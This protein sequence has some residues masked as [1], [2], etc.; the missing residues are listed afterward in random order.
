MARPNERQLSAAMNSHED[1]YDYYGLRIV[2]RKLTRNAVLRN[3]RRWED[4]IP[5][6]DVLDG[7]SAIEI[8]SGSDAKRTLRIARDYFGNS[9]VLLGSNSVTN[10]EDDGEIIM[11]RAVVLESW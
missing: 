8:R 2:E 3:S 11:K 4:G 5:T 7:V 9:A 6:G 10:G 1:E